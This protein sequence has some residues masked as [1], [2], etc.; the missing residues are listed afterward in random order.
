MIIIVIPVRN[1]EQ[2]IEKTL[3]SLKNKLSREHK[4]I[5]IDDFSTDKTREAVE[6]LMVSNKSIEL[7][8]NT[9]KAGIAGALRSGFA[10]MDERSLAVPVMGDSCDE[11]ETIERMY[12]KI[13]D[14]YD[15]V[16]GSRYV[17]NGKRIGKRSLKGLI[18]KLLNKFIQFVSKIPCS[19]LTNSFKMYQA[20]VLKNIDIESKG[21]EISV[22]L[23]LK[24]YFS[25]YKITEVSTIWR[26]REK[27]KSKFHIFNDGYRYIK[28]IIFAMQNRL[29]S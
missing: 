21:F 1:E 6:K 18:S 8:A 12:T 19:D 2:L 25:G 17:N 15:I 10:R 23:L 24:A 7:T 28:W 27:G 9:F 22:E 29:T 11:P 4:I 13:L 14:G 3:A 5:V 20:E 26:A 16:C